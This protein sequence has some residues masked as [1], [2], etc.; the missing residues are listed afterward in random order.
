MKRLALAVILAAA[1]HSAPPAVT[2]PPA[3]VADA[4]PTPEPFGD[5]G[6]TTAAADCETA[7]AN[8][9]AVGCVVETDCARVLCQSNSDPRFV[10]Y[11]VACL[12]H[13]MLPSDVAVCGVDCTLKSASS[14]AHPL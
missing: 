3:D 10:H 4:L 9:D 1:C 12:I 6:P 11:D 8:I 2:A 7:C 13:A 14:L 5:A